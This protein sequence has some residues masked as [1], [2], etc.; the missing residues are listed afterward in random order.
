MPGRI[1]RRGGSHGEEMS[2]GFF[3]LTSSRATRSPEVYYQ[4]ERSCNYS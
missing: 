1:G 2:K 3:G 4:L